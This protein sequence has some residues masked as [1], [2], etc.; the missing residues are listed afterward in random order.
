M[1]TEHSRGANEEGRAARRRGDG[2]GHVPYTTSLLGIQS[3]AGNHNGS[4]EYTGYRYVHLIWNESRREKTCIE[5][6]GKV[7]RTH[8]SQ[9]SIVMSITRIRTKRMEPSSLPKHSHNLRG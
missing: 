7:G 6:K 3:N 2:P 9:V 1:Y 8:L 4:W 5:F